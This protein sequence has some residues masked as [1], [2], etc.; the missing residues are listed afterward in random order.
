MKKIF[1]LIIVIALTLNHQVLFADSEAL[2][3]L[4]REERDAFSKVPAEGPDA[5]F[6]QGLH[7]QQ[8]VNGPET[9]YPLVSDLADNLLLYHGYGYDGGKTY[10]MIFGVRLNRDSVKETSFT[11]SGGGLRINCFEAKEPRHKGLY[12]F[13]ISAG[14]TVM[15][16]GFVKLSPLVYRGSSKTEVFLRYA[17][18]GSD[19]KPDLPN[20]QGRGYR[21]RAGLLIMAMCAEGNLFERE[22]DE[23]TFFSGAFD[24][25]LPH[26]QSL[27]ALLKRALNFRENGQQ[28]LWFNMRDVTDKGG[29]AKVQPGN[30]FDELKKAPA[31]TQRKMLSSLNLQVIAREY[32]SIVLSSPELDYV[33]KIRDLGGDIHGSFFSY[34]NYED[35]QPDRMA[36]YFIVNGTTVLQTMAGVSY[37]W[38]ML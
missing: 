14:A 17:I 12:I 18:H 1:N 27:R 21:V 28:R 37:S 38:Q 31:A 16:H 25:E 9:T 4:A 23:L 3:Q 8:R 7:P 22:P 15:G 19:D 35:A 30:S 29:V 32:H 20:Y 2:R 10:P 24:E 33:I 5:A 13:S 6:I 11:F 34:A 36:E 26:V